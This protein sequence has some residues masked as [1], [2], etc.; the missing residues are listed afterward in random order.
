VEETIVARDSRY[1]TKF[2]RRREGKTDYHARKALV[3]SG[4]LRL[5]TRTSINNIIAQIIVARPKGDEV[6]V[7]AHSR[8]L[9]K[10][11]WKAPRGN[12]SAAYLTGFLC[13]LK[14]KAH[15]VEEAILDIGLYRPTKGARVFAVLKGVLDAKVNIPHSEEKLPDEKR[16]KGEHI[17]KYAESL[18]SDV[19]EYQST[20]SG[21]LKQEI[22]PETLPKH[23]EQVKK[24]MVEAFQSRGKK[25]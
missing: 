16:I 1:C 5:V 12:L 20:W 8:E 11:G 21:Y 22:K 25:N 10:Y 17:A 3:L 18:A 23:F 14:A 4:K 7:S 24:Q 2:R 15:G 13:G 9:V 19:E 6:L